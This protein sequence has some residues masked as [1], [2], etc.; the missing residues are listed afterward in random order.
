[1]STSVV[2]PT[3]QAVARS[4]TPEQP[5]KPAA[6]PS[7]RSLLSCGLVG[8]SGLGASRAAA[9]DETSQ[10][11]QAQ[12]EHEMQAPNMDRL[13]ANQIGM[14]SL[15]S[16]QLAVSVYPTFTYDASGGGGIAQA[17]DLGG[18]RL[19]VTFDA[20][21]LYIPDV[22]YKTAKFM[23]A[24]MVP[25]FRIKIK[26]VKLEGEIN[27]S[28]GEAALEFVA[29]FMFTAGPL[30]KAPP[31]H[32]VTHLTTEEVQGSRRN[33]KG[34]RLDPNGFSRLVGCA[35]VPKT[36]SWPIDKFLMLPDE[37]FAVMVAQFVFPTA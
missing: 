15:E 2:R 12:A 29:D 21:T 32:V 5:A 27:R 4:Q 7:R 6:R 14:R 37:T 35:T 17:Q 26:P 30:Y 13:Q 3:A 9:A 20:D 33:G 23:G 11:T 31:L 19:H 24:P 28:T 18:G 25:P 22:N 16:S 34:T 36:D 8:F 10:S 1:M